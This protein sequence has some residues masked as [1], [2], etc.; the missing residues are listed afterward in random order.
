M[1]RRWQLVPDWLA[2][3]HTD[4]SKVT[5][6][7]PRGDWSRGSVGRCLMSRRVGLAASSKNP[8][9]RQSRV[10]LASSPV[11]G[12]G[13]VEDRYDLLGQGLRQAERLAR[14]AADLL[15]SQQS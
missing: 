10:A 1:N 14:P 3:D 15:R 13:R 4:L 7:A 8:G 12:A 9:V 11:W 5:L 2:C 6:V